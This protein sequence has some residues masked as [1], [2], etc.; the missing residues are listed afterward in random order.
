MAGE[1]RASAAT[2][3]D[4]NTII[5]NFIRSMPGGQPTAQENIFTTLAELLTPASTIPLIDNADDAAVDRLLEFLPPTLVSLA[6]ETDDD[7]LL[8]DP[9]TA[10]TKTSAPL[11]T[12]QKKGV[13]RR[14]LRSPQFAQSLNSLTFALRDGGLPTISEALR[15]PVRNGGFMRR[16]GIPL[17]GGDAVEAF[18]DGVKGH[19]SGDSEPKE[20]EMDTE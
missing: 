16:G 15:I 18:L 5:Q 19:V 13:L 3:M 20:P 14:V 2:P 17:G 10:G 8:E 9:A 11:T 4:A 12:A 7:D 1:R 6:Q